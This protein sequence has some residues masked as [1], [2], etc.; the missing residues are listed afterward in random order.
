MVDS[1]LHIILTLYY[2]LV[3]LQG[4]CIEW[5]K[6]YLSICEAV[7][8]ICIENY[9]NGYIY[10]WHTYSCSV[11]AQTLPRGVVAPCVQCYYQGATT[12][13]TKTKWFFLLAKMVEIGIHT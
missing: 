9:Q 8:N 7:C 5:K 3:I 10:T 1:I 2:Y 4:G 12:P 11:R 13:H 6:H